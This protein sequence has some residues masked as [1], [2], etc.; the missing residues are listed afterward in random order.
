MRLNKK[1][2]TALSVLS[3]VLLTFT[4]SHAAQDTARVNCGGSAYTDVAG[5]AWAADSGFTGGQTYSEAGTTI[6]NTADQTLYQYERWDSQ[7]FS[8]NFNVT[9]G[10]YRVSLYEA[11]L[12]SAVCNSGGRVFN[13][14]INGTQVLTNYDMYNEVGCLTAQIKQFVVVTTDGK[15]NITFTLGT[16]SNPK[17]D[18][19]EIVPGTTISISNKL[20]GKQSWLSISNLNGGLSIQT[21]AEG[22]YILELSN[23]QGKRIGQKHGFGSGV[24]SFKNLNP[25]LYLLTSRMGHQTVTRTVNVVR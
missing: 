2:P 25:G 18:A 4:F 11:S 9:P 13:V 20:N 7:P 19:I 12:Y 24:Q 8:Y 17:I 16:A 10:S 22:A 21:Q 3:T 14:S 15:I 6:N 23:L 5:H 1:L